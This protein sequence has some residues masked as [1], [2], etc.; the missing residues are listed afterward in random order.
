MD[1]LFIGFLRSSPSVVYFIITICN[2]TCWENESIF[3]FVKNLLLTTLMADEQVPILQRVVD[4]LLLKFLLSF[5]N[6]IIYL[7]YLNILASLANIT[8]QAIT[9]FYQYSK[10][11]ILWSSKI[12]FSP[13]FPTVVPFLETFALIQFHINK[14]LQHFF[15]LSNYTLKPHP[16]QSMK[17]LQKM[18][19]I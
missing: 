15:L 3:T 18:H 11:C 7:N 4:S 5:I 1:H 2:L 6:L 9:E 14:F 12:F 17:H 13:E 10:L 16:L 8:H 19:L